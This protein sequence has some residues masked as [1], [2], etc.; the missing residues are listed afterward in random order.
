V[1]VIEIIPIAGARANNASLAEAIR[2]VNDYVEFLTDGH[3]GR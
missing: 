1:P 2:I 3:R